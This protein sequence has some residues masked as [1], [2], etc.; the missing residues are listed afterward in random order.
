MV[1]E[2]P[3]R[4][5]A[6]RLRVYIADRSVHCAG[7]TLDLAR[8]PA[9]LQ[10]FRAFFATRDGKVRRETLLYFMNNFREL[11]SSSERYLES[12]RSNCIKML[13]RARLLADTHLQGPET[14]EFDW[15]PYDHA[16]KTWSLLGVRKARRRRR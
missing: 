16:S 12:R 6:R 5:R 4:R 9:M 10:L 1:F 14:A 15:F 11:A 7:R 8:S 2:H 3:G 13:S